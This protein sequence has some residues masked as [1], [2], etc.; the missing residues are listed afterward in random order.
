MSK[1]AAPE[2]NAGSMADIAFLLLIFFLVTTTIETDSGI[3]RK[4]PPME[5]SDVDV[6]IK[7]KN[8]FTVLLN[9]KLLKIPI[10]IERGLRRLAD[11]NFIGMKTEF[12]EGSYSWNWLMISPTPEEQTQMGVRERKRHGSDDLTNKEKKF[13]AKNP[14]A[15]IVITGN[16]RII[17]SILSQIDA[18]IGVQV[19]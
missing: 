6:I 13:L 15:A 12:Y 17:K 5:E 9:G 16:K 18:A 7:Q 14:H 10:R 8:I 19:K 2:V 11:K 1:R 3:N 4:L